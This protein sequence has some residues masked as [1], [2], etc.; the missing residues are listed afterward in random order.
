[1]KTLDL[2]ER[3]RGRN[4]E[5]IV[6]LTIILLVLFVGALNPGFLSL[7]TVFNI[8]RNSYEPLLF[9]LGVMLV[10]LM[11]GIDVSFDAVGIFAGYTTSVLIANGALPGHLWLMF[12]ISMLIGVALGAINALIVSLGR[13]SILIVTLGTRGIFVG[14]LLAFIGSSFISNLPMSLQSFNID[15]IY[16][17]HTTTGQL[18]GLQ[19]LVIP[20]AIVC[21]LIDFGLRF[22]VIGRGIYAIGGSEEAARRAGFSVGLIKAIVFCC[23]GALAGIAGMVHV[24]LIGFAN[25][26]DIVGNELIVIAAVVLGGVSISGGRGSVL[27]TVLGVLLLELIWYCLIILGVQ[28]T[29]DNVAIGSMIFVGIALQV[30][31]APGAIKLSST[32]C[33]KPNGS[34]S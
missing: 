29:W 6:A 5:G 32:R 1:M 8:L 21:L 26:Q 25:P 16:R 12:L 19:V 3:L 7:A 9:A 2:L 10:L 24:S 27:G 4:N 14:V 15:Y 22:T 20:I 31:R 34:P 17:T 30:K 18:A 28:S 13:L 11:G 23:A 33:A